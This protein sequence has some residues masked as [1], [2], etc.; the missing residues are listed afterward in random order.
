MAD[1]PAW[2]RN[3]ALKEGVFPALDRVVGRAIRG[4]EVDDRGNIFFFP[5]D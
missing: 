5:M 1:M 4:Y 3:E 2:R